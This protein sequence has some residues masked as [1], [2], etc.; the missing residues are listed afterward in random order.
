MRFERKVCKKAAAIILAFVLA[1]TLALPGTTGQ[2]LA[3]TAE[4]GIM[5]NG[6][7]LDNAQAMTIKGTTM[8]PIRTVS[9]QLGYSV[10]WNQA[11]GRIEIGSAPSSLILTLGSLTATSGSTRIAM[12]QAPFVRS[13]TTYVPLRLV[14]SQMGVAVRWEQSSGTVY[15]QS[16]L[17]EP[18]LPTV[19]VAP[20]TDSTVTAIN[21]ISFSDNRLTLSADGAVKPQGSVLKSPDRIVVDL[22]SSSFGPGLLQ[23]QTASAGQ[24]V[25]LP[26]TDSSTV[27][28]IRYSLF[29]QSPSTVR[30]VIDLNRATGHNLYTQGNLVI[31]DLNDDGAAAPIGTDGKKVVVIDPG[32]GDQDS[33]GVGITGKLEKHM[34]LSVSLK[35]AALLKQEPNIDLIM[36]RTDDTFIPLDGRVKIAQDAKADVFLSI[37]GNAASSNA[38]GTE[39]FYADAKRSKALSDIIQKHV[40]AATGFR[41][42]GSK[43]ANYLVIRKTTMPAA[44]LE[45]GFLTNANEEK[46][47]MQ[48]AFQQKV[49]V[50]I[51]AGIKEYLK[52][53]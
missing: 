45:I 23:N 40:L 48:D 46:L 32:H 36:T 33:G 42:R 31:V 19:P 25:T 5:L 3:A 49:A 12:Q 1:V 20:P 27:K 13:N 10:N 41:D 9:E 30:V 16:E 38:G 26:V 17:E 51:V 28:Q 11:T 39:T 53:H 6:K 4:P 24:I 47:M 14:S 7:K 43:Q 21:S 2:A 8:V 18:S 35:V 15:L 37:H 52:T 50:A 22:P 34:V 29:S 44:L